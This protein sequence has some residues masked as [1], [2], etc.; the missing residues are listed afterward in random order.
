[1]ADAGAMADGAA[2]G[3]FDGGAAG[4]LGTGGYAMFGGD[5]V[6]VL[7][8]GLWYGVSAHTNSEAEA[9]TLHDFMKAVVR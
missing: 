8:H 5:E 1:M 4:R 7:G 2:I 3:Y 9:N 6:C